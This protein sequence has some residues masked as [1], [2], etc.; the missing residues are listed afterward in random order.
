MIVEV[1]S[2]ERLR[3]L[4]LPLHCSTDRAFVEQGGKS[5]LLVRRYEETSFA[6]NLK[7]LYYKIFLRAKILRDFDF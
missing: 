7:L 5:F 6:W 4:D 3:E 1:D 2:P